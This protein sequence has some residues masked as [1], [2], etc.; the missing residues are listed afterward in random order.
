MEKELQDRLEQI[1]NSLGLAKWNGTMWEKIKGVTVLSES[2]DGKVYI[3]DTHG[4]V[5][6]IA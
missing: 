2:V 3:Q 6:R 1:K 5:S 4:R